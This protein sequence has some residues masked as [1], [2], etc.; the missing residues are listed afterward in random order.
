MM[1]QHLDSAAPLLRARPLFEYDRYSPAF[2]ART[3][4]ITACALPILIATSKSEV[5]DPI[6]QVVKSFVVI[7]NI[8]LSNIYPQHQ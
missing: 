3:V 4:A 1:T 5:S 2:F 6:R 7:L 8:S